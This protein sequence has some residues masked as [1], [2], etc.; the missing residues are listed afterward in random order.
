MAESVMGLFKAEPAGTAPGAVWAT[1]SSP[2]G[3]GRLV[4]P[5]PAALSPGLPDPAEVE[6]EHYLHQHHSAERPLAAELTLH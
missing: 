3:L 6:T 5:Q 1:S 4:Q 2:P